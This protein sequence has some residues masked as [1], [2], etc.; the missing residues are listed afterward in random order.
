MKIYLIPLKT[1]RGK[2]LSE[3]INIKVYIV[4]LM[5]WLK[6]LPVKG[7][8][9]W[10]LKYRP[11]KGFRGIYNKMG[12]KNL[13]AQISTHLFNNFHEAA[14]SNELFTPFIKRFLTHSCCMQF[15]IPVIICL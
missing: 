15:H 1:A 13:F 3:T 9:V 12:D 5:T 6:P 14:K 2:G 10:P 11:D 4:F 7:F 8:G